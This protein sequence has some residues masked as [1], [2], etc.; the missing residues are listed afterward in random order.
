[1][2]E[3]VID[4]T[5]RRTI[6]DVADVYPLSPMQEGILFHHL[7]QGDGAVIPYLIELSFEVRGPLDVDRFEESWNRLIARHEVLRSVFNF[8]VA[9][10]PLQVVLRNRKIAIERLD[11]SGFDQEEQRTFVD[12]YRRLQRE[13]PFDL[14]R[15]VLMRVGLVRLDENRHHV[16]WLFHH[17]LMDGWCMNLLQRDLFTI[18]AALV[19]G[20][21]PA[22]P[23][24]VPYR[25]YIR[26]IES[27][28]AK[29]SLAFW[30]EFLAGYEKP[31]VP[32]G[33]RRN[34][35]LGAL[36][37][38]E[39][40]FDERETAALRAAGG[41][42]RATLN[43]V[44][45][46]AWGLLL[47]RANDTDDVVFGAVVAARPPDVEGVAE[48]VGLCMNT[49]PFRLRVDDDATLA[50]L[51]ERAR[52]AA[53]GGQEHAWDSLADI[54]SQSAAKRDLISHILIFESYPCDIRFDATQVEPL[55]GL[56]LEQFDSSMPNNY[57]FQIAVFPGETIRIVFTW[58]EGA[59]APSQIQRLARQLRRVLTFFATTP[60]MRTG[61]VDVVEEAERAELLTYD[62]TPLPHET[63]AARL[64]RFFSSATPA[65]TADGRTL[66]WR[67]LDARS[68][69]L[70]TKLG[71]AKR[72]AICL[73][74]NLDFAIA[75]VACMRIGAAF[76][77]IDP[78]NPKA[79]TEHI[80][81]DC[82]ADVV[83]TPASFSLRP[84]SL[85]SSRAAYVL[86]TSGT[87]GKPKGVMI[88][89]AS[90]INYV[91]WLRD[92][93]GL[94]PGDRTALL[95]SHA[96]DLGY[97]ALFGALL[98]GAHVHLVDERTRRNPE[99]IV[100]L[101]ADAKLTF[102]K[103]TPGLLHLL[104]SASNASRL[105]TSS[106][107]DV[108][109]GGEP[110]VP[111][112]L[113]AFHALAPHVTLRNHYGPTET[114]IGC[115]SGVLDPTS[116]LVASGHQILGRPI[117]GAA[118]F[119]L[120]AQRRPVA[121]GTPGELWI[122]GRGLALGY[123]SGATE[124]FVTAPWDP[125][126]RLYRTGD[127]VERLDDGRF[128]FR[129]RADDQLKIR[130][131]RVE[132]AEIES[133]LRRTPPVRD[134]AVFAANGEL[135]AYVVCEDVGLDVGALRTGLASSLPDYM[136]PSHFVAVTRFPLTANGKVD[137]AALAEH[138][139]VV[140]ASGGEVR[141][142]I[143]TAIRDIWQS[144]LAV[145][146]IGPDDD[147]FILGGHSVKAILALSR[148]AKKLGTRLEVRDLFDHPTV[149]GLA[150]RIEQGRGA[151]RDVA[152]SLRQGSANAP[153]YFFLPPI[154][155][156][157]TI[158]KELLGTLDADVRAWGL[159]CRGFDDDE[160]PHASMA[161]MVAHFV[162]A[163]RRI[164]PRGPYRLCGYSMGVSVALEAAAL[165]EREG[166]R[167]TLILIDGLPQ[168]V[169]PL[170]FESLDDLRTLP[171]WSHILSIVTEHLDADTVGRISR[172]A[173][174]NAQLLR[175]RRF[176]TALRA[177]MYCLE[178]EDNERPA[179]MESMRA[180][181]SGR[182]ELRRTPGAHYTLFQPPHGRALLRHF[183][184][185]VQAIAAKEARASSSP[186]LHAAPAPAHQPVLESQK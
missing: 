121:P 112:D 181:T 12:G 83:I 137:R 155:G 25:N 66:T 134:A 150:R 5:A 64:S 183:H 74:P 111:A 93:I 73:P 45:Q 180:L 167:V 173:R 78:A 62:V 43:N 63:L 152:I 91:S 128:V 115:L 16:V 184:A 52:I 15:D 118:A 172:V 24:A 99:A 163:I 153:A 166:E 76:I 126:L 70:A 168:L 109:I 60:A 100:D 40:E 13:T 33:W 135:T 161:D 157:S 175:G 27:R 23:P 143:E 68:A 98:N 29:E 106:L 37:R 94:T 26:R 85:T 147:F 10:R 47:A 179:G 87:T 38:L 56:V 156:T 81:A 79:R 44:I 75:V 65:V 8:R 35:E 49:V 132:P 151:R 28:D 50:T 86:Y 176:T 144:V 182:F 90:L 122:G 108:F 129:G 185:I 162:S 67:E 120:D 125:S 103:L 165:L 160:T 7:Y 59:F 92:T 116:A 142:E 164:Q 170:D 178:A 71:D 77:P 48:M 30:R 101:I 154:L 177:D 18:Y 117:H 138:Q 169:E 131:Y 105:T 89:D 107:R 34:V 159:Q 42:S 140:R 58:R 110:F 32:P 130:G 186:R 69:E 119:V 127:V 145:E 11:A 141:G 102:L 174:N 3:A 21:E 95:S 96:F 82:A 17:I 123:T 9:E 2:K 14:T 22:L 19:E 36:R 46:A 41:A 88:R 4:T 61:D 171:H 133:A 51:V 53:V 31:V 57:A 136:I 1:M 80:L 39:L 139:P 55:P 146:N 97:T 114:T 113:H 158:Y 6:H 149:R 124:R 72:V 104:V 84:S 148:I 20:R 54:Q